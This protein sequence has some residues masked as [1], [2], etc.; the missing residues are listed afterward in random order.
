MKNLTQT[1]PENR[2]DNRRDKAPTPATAFRADAA[3]V[4]VATVVAALVWAGARAA[5]IDLKVRSG[6]GSREV[7]LAAVILTP[8]LVGFAAVRLL[9]LLERRTA[10][11]LRIWT[12]VAIAVWAVSFAG[13][14]S[15]TAPSGGLVLAALHLMVGVV[16]VVGLRLRR[17]A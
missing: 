6:S 10:R 8:L 9:R 7:T 11:G 3:V 1:R 14:L 12:I 5:G 2:P 4:L 13:P 17:V 16:V 15:A